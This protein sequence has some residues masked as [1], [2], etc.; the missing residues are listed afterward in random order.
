M[1][2]DVVDTNTE[3]SIENQLQMRCGVFQVNVCV[4]RKWSNDIKRLDD[5]Q[6]N[7]LTMSNQI[8][9]NNQQEEM[10]QNRYESVG[11]GKLKWKGWIDVK[12][13]RI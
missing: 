8:K 10:K 3:Y 11:F 7:E 13:M 2:P 5:E 12:L 4:Q 6:R 9:M 1:I